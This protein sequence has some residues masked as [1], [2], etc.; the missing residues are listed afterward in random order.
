MPDRANSEGEWE[1][2][3][4]PLPAKEAD[5]QFDRWRR[6]QATRDS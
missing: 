4:P 3:V 2:I 6:E 1:V 5:E